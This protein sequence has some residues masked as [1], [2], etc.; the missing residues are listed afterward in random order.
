MSEKDEN[1]IKFK[2]WKKQER[3]PYVIYADFESI[4]KKKSDTISIHE[5]SGY[6]LCVV[7]FEGKQ[8]DCET[9]RDKDA[10]KTFLT[11]LFDLQK[12]LYWKIKNANEKMIFTDKDKEEFRKAT[13]CCICEKGLPKKSTYV[14]HIG[15]I[16]AW[17]K[18]MG[19]PRCMP[20]FKEVN[21]KKNSFKHI[22]KKS[23]SKPK[24]IYCNIYKKITMLL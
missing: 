5:I 11:R 19:L 9:Y 14:D 23:L 24:Q 18:T 7:D 13:K 6:S 22:K 10:G 15:N 3:A 16:Q 20:T 1:M 8:M 17:L 2:D 12:E 21:N 4:I